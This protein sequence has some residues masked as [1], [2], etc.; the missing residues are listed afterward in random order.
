MFFK[1]LKQKIKKYAQNAVV[2]AEKIFGSGNGMAKKQAAIDFVISALRLPAA[3]EG[4]LTF[5]LGAFIDAAIESA[6]EL[7]KNE[8]AETG[9]Q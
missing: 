1:K 2:D 4:L 6:V 3:L 5:F 7:L 8:Q 9:L